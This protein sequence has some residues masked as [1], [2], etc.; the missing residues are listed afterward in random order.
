MG[1]ELQMPKGKTPTITL[2]IH[3]KL[4]EGS[5]TLGYHEDEFAN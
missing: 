5:F 1:P 2:F 3:F 4:L